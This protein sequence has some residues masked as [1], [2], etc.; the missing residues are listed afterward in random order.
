MSMVNDQSIE[1]FLEALASK[2]PTPG[3]GSAVA[4]LGAMGAALVSMVANLTI[5]KKNYESVQTEM[6]EILQD[7]D[8]LR[9]RILGL[10][11][12]DMAAFDQVMAA[13]GLPK[14]TENEKAARSE[15]IQLGLKAATEAPLAAALL[16]RDV[17]VLCHAVAEK[18]NRNVISDAGVGVLSAHAGFRS[19]I[20]NVRVN[21]GAIRDEAFVKQSLET[22]EKLG[23][24]LDALVEATYQIVESRL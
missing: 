15:A 24:N 2:S 5:G 8:A 6:V 17:V 3:G 10:V 1:S 20:L 16:C 4:V 21:T 13:Y 23:K 11:A 22:M 14:E 18:G 9:H 19:A 7:A 12:A